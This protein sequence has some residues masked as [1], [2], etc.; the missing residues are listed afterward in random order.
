MRSSRLIASL[1][2]V[3]V[4]A[5]GVAACGSSSSGSSSTSGGGSKSGGTINGAGST[6]AAPIY[7]QWG[8]TLRSQDG[9]TVNYQPVGSGQG[10]TELTAGT[11]DFAGSDPPMKPE[12]VSA[13][14]KKGDPLH[15]PMA[16]GA[17]TISYNL[18]GVKGGLKLTGPVIADIFLG[19]VK[20]W[21]DP[22]IAKLNPG[23]NLP[24]TDITVVHRSDSSGTTKGFTGYLAAVSPTWSKQVGSDKTV[25]WPTGTGAKGNDGVA[26]AV[27]QTPGAVGY[28]EQ[29][30]ALQN[31]FTTASVQNKAGNY[32]TPSLQ[33]TTAAGEGLTVPANLQFTISDPSNPQA[34]PITSQT[35]VITY[36]DPC[37]AGASQSVA[38]GIKSFLDYAYGAGQT[39]LGQLQYAKLPAAIESKGKA[40]ISKLQCNGKAL[41]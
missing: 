36:Q 23:V 1:A 33:S 37:K 32:V 10:I 31:K 14:K 28:V 19:K 20:K 24:S 35:F 8:S 34:Y 30:Y 11:V 2:A 41:S 39:T 18:S 29:A 13:A 22:E 21:N 27:K 16:L 17:I 3:C 40:Q 6:F 9:M 25:K 5:I 38:N 15:F 12:E 4:L 7:Q 26:A